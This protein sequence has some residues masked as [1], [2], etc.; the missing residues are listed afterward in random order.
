ME[1]SRFRYD[2]YTWEFILVSLRD[3]RK[4]F[5]DYIF[6]YCDK[7]VMKN[8]NKLQKDMNKLLAHY[9]AISSI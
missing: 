2:I 3:I 7:F 4:I 9:D 6:A 8:E 5:H 1:K